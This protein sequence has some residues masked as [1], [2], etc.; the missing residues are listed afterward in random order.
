MPA[1]MN[2]RQRFF[3]HVDT[4][5][6]NPVVAGYCQLDLSRNAGIFIYGRSYCDNPQAFALDP[7]NLPLIYNERFYF[8]ITR[9][10]VTGIPS[11]LLDSGPDE[12]GKRIINRLAEPKPMTPA[13]YLVLGSGFGIGALYFSDSAD[14]IA[15]P[16]R[17]HNDE[18]VA[19]YHSALALDEDKPD[20][21]EVAHYLMPSS[22]IGGARPKAPWFYD[23]HPCIAKF[24]R[25]D[26]PFDNALA[27]YCMMKLAREVGIESAAVHIL[28]TE[29]GHALAV[30]RFDVEEHN[31]R[32]L[33]SANALLNIRDMSDLGQ[34]SYDQIAAVGRKI[35]LADDIGEQLFT[36]MLF[37]IAIGNTDDHSRNHAFIKHQGDHGYDLSPAYDLVPVPYRLGAHA[38]NLGPFGQSVTL[39]N[40]TGGGRLMRLDRNQQQKC[41]QAVYAVTENLNERLAALGMPDKDIAYLQPCFSQMAKIKA[42][43]DA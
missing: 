42:L 4:G 21:D 9:F 20:L 1:R 17:A 8:P 34:T 25:K 35:G 26:D 3:V 2:N 15:P 6:G 38:I 30:E 32:H 5:D 10:Q 40:I 11:A 33:L 29:L 18:I 28:E 31:R 22:G 27:E 24:N 14:P 7:V 23:G 41:A 36:R 13:D 43:A 12:W 19:L 16:G 37:N 39:D